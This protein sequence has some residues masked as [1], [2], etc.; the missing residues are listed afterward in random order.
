MQELYDLGF[1]IIPA[2]TE[3][4]KVPAVKWQR[5]Q[6][7]R[8]PPDL[9]GTWQASTWL[10]LTGERNGIVVIDI[11]DAAAFTLAKQ[12]LPD[13]PVKGIKTEGEKEHW[14][15]RMAGAERNKAGIVVAGKEYRLDRRGDGGYV[16][17]GEYQPD[18]TRMAECPVYSADWFPEWNTPEFETKEPNYPDYPQDEAYR[19][20]SE[21]I[22][23]Q[24]GTQEGR[25]ASNKCFAIA[26][27][28]V[29]GYA[30]PEEQA[31]HLI[32]QWGDKADQLD[33]L[34]NWRPWH[35]SQLIHKLEDAIKHI[36]HKGSA[37]EDPLHLL[38]R[39]ALELI[40]CNK[41]QKRFL[42]VA[43]LEA[44]STEETD[45][46]VQ[47]ILPTGKSAVLAGQ[48]KIG[49]STL[50][51]YL[52]S[53][54]ASGNDFFWFQT[55]PAPV[56][57]FE[58]EQELSEVYEYLKAFGLPRANE[59]V[60]VFNP[61]CTQTGFAATHLTE[62]VNECGFADS[63]RGL[64]VID[65]ARAAFRATSEKQ[66]DWENSAS[67]VRTICHPITQWCHNTGWNVLIIH[68]TNKMLGISGS[69]DWSG[70]MDFVMTYCNEIP[71][72]G[73]NPRKLTCVGR[74][75]FHGGPN[76]FYVTESDRAL[77]PMTFGEYKAFQS[78]FKV[79]NLSPQLLAL[80]PPY[81]QAGKTPEE[82]IADIK[83]NRQDVYDGLHSLE[84]SG[85]VA[86]SKK[87]RGFAYTKAGQ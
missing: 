64:I 55:A 69:T 87:G 65:T 85:K 29:D 68:H 9:F 3:N 45:W 32:C 4:H 16:R 5:W 22:A 76:P 79:E 43:D 50:V 70:A 54:L 26:S 36:K 27:K 41:K 49:K 7:E 47:N 38:E 17:L 33:K 61:N 34:G 25:G 86:K 62:A 83:K 77:K 21:W 82:L 37:L 14:Y 13:T 23:R 67:T 40:K 58:I 24:E 75:G 1:N 72:R 52:L 2:S 81:G 84:A 78:A 30:L 15:Y 57:L 56:I 80:L 51:Y 11:D 10:L 60:K 19:Q 8:I 53:C 48:S 31:L 42:T 28:L 18:L 39:Q 35:R 59:T 44:L 12:R 63:T 73:K 20:A 6:T 46:L 71:E 74:Y 66:V